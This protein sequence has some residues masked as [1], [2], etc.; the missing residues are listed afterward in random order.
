MRLWNCGIFDMEEVLNQEPKREIFSVGHTFTIEGDDTNY[1]VEKVEMASEVGQQ[2]GL[3]INREV[4]IYWVKGVSPGKQGGYHPETDAVYI[5]E[6]NT[7]ETTLEH[8]LVHVVEYRVEP[9]PQL[10]SLYERAK[11]I[12]T[13]DSF[14]GGV[15]AFIFMRNVHEF[16][17]E[18]KTRPE[19]IAAL[20][21]EGL[22]EEFVKETNYIFE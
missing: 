6:N 8:E 1:I 4:P 19:F 12:I 10:I 9:T 16:I 18:G 14:S 11:K 2:F 21:K 20:K 17:A 7:D 5:F 3:K 15:F 13:E 22:Y